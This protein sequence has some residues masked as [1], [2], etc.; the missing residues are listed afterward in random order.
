MDIGNLKIKIYFPP[1]RTLKICEGDKYKNRSFQHNV[2]SDNTM[3]CTSFFGITE[4][5]VSLGLE[6]WVT[7]LRESEALTKARKLERMFQG[8]ENRMNTVLKA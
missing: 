4:N 7:E 6:G 1:L 2:I 8:S 3:M 5:G